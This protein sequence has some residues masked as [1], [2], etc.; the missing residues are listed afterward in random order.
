MSQLGFNLLFIICGAAA[1]LAV[2][3]ALTQKEGKNVIVECSAKP[4]ETQQDFSL[5][6]NGTDITQ[7]G[8]YIGSKVTTNGTQ[9]QY[10][11]LTRSDN[12]IVFECELLDGFTLQSTV[13]TQGH[14][15]IQPTHVVYVACK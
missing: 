11:P 8:K 4:G 1:V 10:G 9:F 7:T 12:G 6:V 13:P 15:P 5:L 3:E 2:P 14:R